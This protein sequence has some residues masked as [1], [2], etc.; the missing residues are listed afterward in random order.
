VL[1]IR[2]SHLEAWQSI[3]I[4]KPYEFLLENVDNAIAAAGGMGIFGYLQAMWEWKKS[5]K[6]YVMSHYEW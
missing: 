6:E 1:H 3:H 4:G 5:E 2:L